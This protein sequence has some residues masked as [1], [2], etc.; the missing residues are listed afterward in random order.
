MSRSQRNGAG[1]TSAVRLE[2]LAEAVGTGLQAQAAMLLL[3]VVLHVQQCSESGRHA[4]LVM[5]TS[6]IHFR[7]K[8]KPNSAKCD[9][10]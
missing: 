4:H 7:R 2:Y 3:G 10:I 9:G 8:V 5:D 1:C 6:G